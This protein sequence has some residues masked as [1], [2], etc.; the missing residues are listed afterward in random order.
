MIALRLFHRIEIFALNVLD[1]RDFERVRIADI[2]RHDRH[3]VQ[4]GDLRR[5]PAALAGDDLVAILRAAH[6]PHHDRLD[7]AMLLDRIGEFAEFGIGEFAA[8]IARIRLEEFDRHLA[9]RARPIQM[10]GFAADISDQTCKTA[11]KS[12]TR[13]VGHR[14]LPWIQL[15]RSCFTSFPE[16]APFRS[17]REMPSANACEV[18]ARAGSLPS[19]V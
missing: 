7:H 11:T 13:F 19:R 10:R 1:D 2:D 9:L 8:R 16:T 3:L 15:K 17:G 5:T 4:A 18:R 6:R 14:Q 12:R